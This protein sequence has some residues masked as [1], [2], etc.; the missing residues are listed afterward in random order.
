MI[1]WWDSVVDRHLKGTCS[2][3]DV[4]IRLDREGKVSGLYTLFGE[5]VK[6]V[7]EDEAEL[8]LEVMK[9]RAEYIIQ[10]LDRIESLGKNP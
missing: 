6:R 9:L 10:E 5:T 2:R 3:G 4:W 1:K 7:P 8:D